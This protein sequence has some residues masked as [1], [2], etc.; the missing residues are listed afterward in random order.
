MQ[1]HVSGVNQIPIL[2]SHV[3]EFNLCP[4]VWRRTKKFVTV[5]KCGGAACFYWS[6]TSHPKGGDSLALPD[7]WDPY[8]HPHRATKFCMV[9]KVGDWELLQGLPLGGSGPEGVVSGQK[10]IARMLMRD[11]FAVANYSS[12][13]WI[14]YHESLWWTREIRA[15]LRKGRASTHLSR[16]SGTVTTL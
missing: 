10:I 16:N 7:F 2:H 4:N 12:V 15:R 1:R 6:E 11:L 5:T 13:S 9:I 3:W 8:V 14:S